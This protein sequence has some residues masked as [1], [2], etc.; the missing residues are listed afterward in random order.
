MAQA[1]QSEP[2]PLPP[3]RLWYGFAAAPAA[4]AIQGILG[5]IV[6]AQLC[7]ADLPN[8]GLMGEN[9]VRLTLALITALLWVIAVSAGLVSFRNW[10]SLN[11]HDHLVHAQGSSRDAF[12]CL[13][14]V[15]VSTV[16]SAAL[17]WAGLPFILLQQ[18]MRAR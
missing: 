2:H 1:Y 18:C 7:P 8:W 3:G 6:S 12:L 17:L 4:W 10:Q 9:G 15:L 16:F 5:V 13:G 14:G 11:R